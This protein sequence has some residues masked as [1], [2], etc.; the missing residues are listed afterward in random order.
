MG[1]VRVPGKANLTRFATLVLLVALVLLLAGC[2]GIDPGKSPSASFAVDIPVK[3]AF[4]RAVAQTKFC[5]VTEDRFPMTAEIAPDGQSAFVR[6]NMT[7][8][9]TLLSDV[10]I[11]ALPGERSQVDVQMW[12]VNVWDMTAVDAM[13]AAIEFGVPSCVNYFPSTTQTRPRR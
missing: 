6:V 1:F 10:R 9:G 3:T 8:A 4:D 2:K 13:K 7:M 11:A 5:L 12:G